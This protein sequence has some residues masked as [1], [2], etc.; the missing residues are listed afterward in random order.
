ME[1][2]WGTCS[3]VVNITKLLNTAKIPKKKVFNL[4]APLNQSFFICIEFCN[5]VGS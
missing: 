5:V 1:T 2:E 4:C 3:S